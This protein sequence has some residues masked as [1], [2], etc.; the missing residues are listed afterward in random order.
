MENTRP[1][2][3]VKKDPSPWLGLLVGGWL[4]VVY[5]LINF[6]LPEWISWEANRYFIQPAL[7]TILILICL[8]TWSFTETKIPFQKS[9][10]LAAALV[11]LVQVIIFFGYAL[12]MDRF[13]SSPY[14]SGLT[15]TLKNLLYAVPIMLAFETSRGYF[16]V[17]GAKKRPVLSF[18]LIS[19]IY[20][21]LKIQIPQAEQLVNFEDTFRFIGGVVFPGL[22]QNLLATFLAMA[23]GPLASISYF[24]VLLPFEWVSPILPNLTWQIT[25]LFGTLTP[26]ISLVVLYLASQ[27][28]AE[29]ISTKKKSFDGVTISW[30]VTLGLTAVL[31]WFNSGLLGVQPFLISGHSMEPQFRTGDIVITKEVSFEIIQVND[32]VRYHNADSEVVHRVIEIKTAANGNVIFITQGDNN[33]TTDDPVLPEQ[34]SGKVILKIPK[35]GWIAIVLRTVFTKAFG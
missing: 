2:Q 18:L 29:N 20:T 10:I 8:L 6:L 17:S 24:G 3:I 33:N 5:V 22:A 27:E 16:A 32:I 1:I 30:I 19:L 35:L 26:L 9:A 28:K 12:F 7:W 25:A 13:G 23:R 14:G 31:V 21:L 34:I 4:L 15:A 11:G